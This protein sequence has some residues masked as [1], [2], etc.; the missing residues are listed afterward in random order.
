[1]MYVAVN[2]LGRGHAQ[3][4]TAKDLAAALC[5]NERTLRELYEDA[6]AEGFLICNDMDG[7]GYYIADTVQDVRR[8]Y[9]RDH[10]RAMALLS[11]LKPMRR[12]LHEAGLLKKGE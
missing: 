4:R 2:R 12:I 5:V 1:M 9:T 11:R 3:A 10:N 7:K 6:R 8:Q